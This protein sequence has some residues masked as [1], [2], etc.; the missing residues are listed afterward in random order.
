MESNQLNKYIILLRGINVGG[1]NIISMK[2][3]KDT[4]IKN[5]F[6]NVISYINSGNIIA[7]HTIDSKS[8]IKSNL[9]EIIRREFKLEVNVLVLNAQELFEMYKHLPKLWNI[10]Q[11]TRYNVIFVIPPMTSEMIIKQLAEFNSEIERVDYYTGVLFWSVKNEYYSKSKYSKIVG[12]SFYSNLTIR[13][14]N[15]FNAL[16]NLL[17]KEL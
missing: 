15:T 17:N 10:D 16:I 13:N 5:G 3:L 7:C 4:L 8:V 1:N 11:E 14:A 6:Y 2:T 12:K 9:E